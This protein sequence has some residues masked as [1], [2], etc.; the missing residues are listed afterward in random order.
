MDNNTVIVG[1]NRR[2]RGGD[3]AG[4]F[5]DQAELDLWTQLNTNELFVGLRAT[6]PTSPRHP[7]I[8]SDLPSCALNL[9]PA[10]RV[11]GTSNKKGQWWHPLTLR[12]RSIPECQPRLHKEAEV[13]LRSSSEKSN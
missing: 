6:H 1:G 8:R 11:L 5:K 13:K 12:F 3:W 10:P 4:S 2:Q 9:G 7:A